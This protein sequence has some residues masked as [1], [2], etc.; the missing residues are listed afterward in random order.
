MPISRVRCPSRRG[1]YSVAADR[2]AEALGTP[3]PSYGERSNVTAFV[4]RRLIARGFGT[5]RAGAVDVPMFTTASVDALVAA[6][7]EVD[8]EHLRNVGK[9]RRSP[10]AALVK[11]KAKEAAAV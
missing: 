8:W 9:G 2:I 3:N 4:V 10:L 7:P 6:H 11:E 5:S 1:T